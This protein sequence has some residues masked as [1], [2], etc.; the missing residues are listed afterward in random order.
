MGKKEFSKA[1]RPICQSAFGAL[2]TQLQY[3]E[4]GTAVTG[5]EP[6]GVKI[7]RQRTEYGKQINRELRRNFEA[8]LSMFLES[9]E[10]K[11]LVD[12]WFGVVRESVL[13][14]SGIAS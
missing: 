7:H 3:N 5:N 8:L 11:G 10:M 14:T 2:A 13:V 1:I 6:I 4:N 9:P 12:V